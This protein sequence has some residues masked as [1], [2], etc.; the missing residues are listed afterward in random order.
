MRSGV[1]VRYKHRK[2]KE[3]VGVRESR[4]GRC[5]RISTYISARQKVPH[6]VSPI[7]ED[8]V[9]DTSQELQAGLTRILRR[10]EPIGYLRIENPC[11]SMH[12]IRLNVLRIN[13]KSVFAQESAQARS[14]HGFWR[15]ADVLV[16]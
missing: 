4:A 5:K 14:S 13:R 8:D 12:W 1:G 10:S 16:C 7:I 11:C 15:R 6:L 9:L 3:H 2:K